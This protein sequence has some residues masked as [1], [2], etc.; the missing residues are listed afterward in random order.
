MA[1]PSE[2]HPPDIGLSLRRLYCTGMAFVVVLSL[3]AVSWQTLS[4]EAQDPLCR[5]S[6]PLARYDDRLAL[7]PDDK[8]W[9]QVRFVLDICSTVADSSDRAI[10]KDSLPRLL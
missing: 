2:H 1:K 5:V 6:D 7:D 8:P 10:T 9:S 4:P 3:V